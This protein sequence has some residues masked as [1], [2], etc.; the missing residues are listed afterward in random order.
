M[1]HDARRELSTAGG[2]K[3]F[4]MALRLGSLL[5]IGMLLASGGSNDPRL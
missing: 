5:P 1:R 2:P 4:G 3:G